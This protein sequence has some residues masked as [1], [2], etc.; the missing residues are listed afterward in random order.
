MPTL[1]H[2]EGDTGMRTVALKP[3]TT[4]QIA[5]LDESAA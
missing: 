2:P 4:N 5:L 3:G 1:D